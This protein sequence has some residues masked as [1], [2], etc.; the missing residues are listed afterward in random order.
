MA[1]SPSVV[2]TLFLLA[3][4]TSLAMAQD[5]PP[6]L[7]LISNVNVF[8]GVTDKL[9]PNMHVLVK[10]NLIATVVRSARCLDYEQQQGDE[11][12]D[13]GTMSNSTSAKPGVGSR[14]RNYGL[15]GWDGGLVAD[16][17]AIG[18]STIRNPQSKIPN[19]R[20]LRRRE[21]GTKPSK[22]MA[23]SATEAGSGTTASAKSLPPL[24]APVSQSAW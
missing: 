23:A 3:L 2:T 18:K 16:D 22:P 12:G 7:V 20:F 10:D 13:N 11:D 4:S 24:S 15:T 5:A 1:K 17:Y 6:K 9:H 19:Y 8:D 14:S 21:N